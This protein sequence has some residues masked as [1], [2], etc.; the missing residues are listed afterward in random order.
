MRY[1]FYYAIPVKLFEGLNQGG[2][3]PTSFSVIAS[4]TARLPGYPASFP[5]PPMRL[6][7]A[8]FYRSLADPPPADQV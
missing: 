7:P 4:Y 6:D 5:D 8:P 3:A 1:R 2:E